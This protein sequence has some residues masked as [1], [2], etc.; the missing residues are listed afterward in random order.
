MCVNICI[1]SQNTCE[2]PFMA[3]TLR[4]G[5]LPPGKAPTIWSPSKCHFSIDL[6]TETYLLL[7]LLFSKCTFNF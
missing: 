4:L 3:V 2:M 5:A 7:L 6:T 1:D